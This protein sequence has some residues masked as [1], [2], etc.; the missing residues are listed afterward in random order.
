LTAA[1][2]LE[3]V[4]DA[5]GG[6]G[7][8][9]TLNELSI[10]VSA[11]GLAVASKFQGRGLRDLVA[12]ISTD[13]QRVVLAPYPSRGHRGVFDRGTVRIE[14]D[15]GTLVRQRLDP[16]AGLG[17]PR[18]LLWW[19][20]LDLLYFGAS[21]LWT[22]MTSPF[23]FASPRF[24]VQALDPWPERGEIWRPLEVTFPAE[25]HTHSQKQVFYFGPDGLIRR[26]DYTAEEFGT[27]A[28]SAHYSDAHRD[29]NGIVMPTR[30]RVLLRRAD[31][32]SRP[33]PVLI[34]IVVRDVSISSRR[35]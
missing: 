8:W 13:I 16:R 7:R 5:H 33:H 27:W 10:D 15:N 35:D 25:L 28:R 11:G 22:Y 20:H 24:Q 31:N 34:W 26:Q 29:F 1:S 32:R 23:I 30:R 9:Q 2:L 17:S 6:A 21:A 14:A 12:R 19:D 4:I 18:H 3:E